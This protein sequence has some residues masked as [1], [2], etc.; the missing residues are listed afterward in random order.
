MKI[1]LNVLTHGDETIGLRVL[2][3]IEKLGIARDVLLPHIANYRAFA[4]GQRYID[5][6]LNR[7]F[8]GDPVGNHEQ[9]LAHAIA[10]LV[11][12][13][14]V[15]IDIH[16]TTS[17]LKDAVI[18]T[19]L[20][21]PTRQCIEAMGP[22]YVL[23]MNATQD[24]ALISA[25]PIGIGFE[26]GQ[27]NDPVALRRTVDDITRLLHYLGVTAVALSP[28]DTPAQYFDVVAEVTK[29]PGY[30]LLPDITNYQLI[31]AGQS[32]AT[33]GTE[34]LR[35]EEDFYPILFGEKSYQHSFGFKGWRIK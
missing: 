28:P 33:N 2:A 14:D 5:Q 7:S 24:N 16:S 13:A 35:A 32:F 18:V 34:Q 11:G 15:V 6:D 26:Y 23:V 10:P 22:R 8:P 4:A 1:I 12:A 3:E 30:E 25:A 19:K 17:Q 20:D 27:D 9:R 21:Q 31:R 29:P